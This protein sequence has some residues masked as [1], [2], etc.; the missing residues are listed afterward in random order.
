MEGL[1]RSVG[2]DKMDYP[3]IF[4]GIV[5]LFGLYCASPYSEK[6]SPV[7]SSKKNRVLLG[8]IVVILSG[9]LISAHTFWLHQKYNEMGGSGGCSAFSV[10][11]CQDV[12][13]NNEYNADPLFGIPWGL[14]GMMAFSLMAV[15]SVSVFRHSDADWVKNWLT[16]GT[17]MSGFG[18][19]IAMYLVYV[20]IFKMGVFCQYCTGAHIAD[21]VSFGMF[22]YLMSMHES[23][24]WAS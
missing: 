7:F 4:Y 9:Y 21:L 11:S 5:L 19:L 23:D 12:I 22:Y 1:L 3:L 10:F 8:L 13:S 17:A 20:E 14:L 2:C 18:V 24:S 16:A 15:I 6:M